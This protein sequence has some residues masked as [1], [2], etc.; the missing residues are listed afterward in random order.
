MDWT[1]LYN[2]YFYELSTSDQTLYNEMYE[3]MIHANDKLKIIVSIAIIV[4]I[5]IFLFY[6]FQGIG[7]FVVSFFIGIA[8]FLL[9]LC[10]NLSPR[11]PHE[12]A[13]YEFIK[14][15]VLS[16]DDYQSVKEEFDIIFL[17]SNEGRRKFREDPESLIKKTISTLNH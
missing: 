4:D 7:A 15:K 3:N 8:I 14:K 10:F 1:L 11:E 13:W 16:S 2:Q 17:N 6:L 12:L 5:A 9:Y